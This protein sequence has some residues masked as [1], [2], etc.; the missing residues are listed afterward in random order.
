MTAAAVPAPRERVK[1][2]AMRWAGMLF[3]IADTF[4]LQEL[5]RFLLTVIDSVSEG[6]PLSGGWLDLSRGA[7]IAVWLYW[8]SH[9]WLI[10]ILT[11]WRS[12]S[13]A[14]LRKLDV[15]ISGVV[16]LEILAIH[17]LVLTW[18]PHWHITPEALW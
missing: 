14:P 12:P 18:R 8:L 16:A 6:H 17:Y 3:L 9:V 10:A 13:S 15:A 7:A 4:L 2:A 11:K 1:P 5:V